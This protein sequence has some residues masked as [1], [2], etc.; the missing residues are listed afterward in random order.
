M[1]FGGHGLQ[2]HV[3]RFSRLIVLMVSQMTITLLKCLDRN[4]P[5]VELNHLIRTYACNVTNL[6]KM[7]A[8]V[9]FLLRKLTLLYVVYVLIRLLALIV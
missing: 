8:G 1:P 4:L 6:G 5:L 9:F 7:K 3:K 2:K